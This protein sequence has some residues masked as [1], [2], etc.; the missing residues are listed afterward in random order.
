[1]GL[2]DNCLYPVNIL[3][4][5]SQGSHMKILLTMPYPISKN[6]FFSK[7][8]YPCL[9]LQ[10]VAG[11]TPREHD[12][13]IV[14][15]RFEKINFNN[16]YDLVGVSSLT[17]N[18]LRGYEIADIFRKLGIKVV[19]GGYHASLLPEEA[20]K[21]A[22]SVVIGE[23]ELTWPQVLKDV[24]NGKLKPYYRANKFVEPENIP[25][26]RHD[27]GLYTPFI[28]AMQASRGCP[29]GCEFCAMHKIE[30]SI[31]RGRPVDHVTREIEFI[32]AKRVFFG[33]AS[34][35]VNP[36]YTKMLFRGLKDLNKNY[37]CWGNINVLSRDDEFLRLAREAGVRKW[38]V[39]IESISQETIDSVGKTTNKV[40]NYG[41][42]IKKIRDHGMILTG[43]FMF[44]FDNDTP[45][46]FQKT[47][48][49]MYEWELDEASFS[50]LTPYPNTRL[51]NRLK[52]EGRITSYD[53]SRYAEGNLNFTPKKMSSEELL[54][55]IT[56][57]ANDFF[58]FE[59]MLYRSAKTCK[60]NPFKLF[61][62]LGSNIGLRAFYKKDKFFM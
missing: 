60:Y 4:N 57:I 2:I 52:E 15:E 45:D 19:F 54:D 11:I 27:I 12:V 53:W 50:I 9:T 23:A 21:H 20:K 59:R 37:E 34:L 30:G 48:E 38:Y 40:E 36:R 29:T 3:I 6:R 14:D 31:F 24:E 61:I 13:Q 7:F 41:K 8:T 49:A 18:S 5:I 25:P 1:M 39:G 16:H 28:E 46:I 33:D 62:T 26:A 47:L 58:S 10:Q 17:Y 42:G 43:F 35:T 44:G 55:G 32:K 22:D 51:F 56:R